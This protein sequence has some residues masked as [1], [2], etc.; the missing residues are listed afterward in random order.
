MSHLLLSYHAL[1]CTYSIPLAKKLRDCGVFGVS[2]DEYLGYAERNREEW[3]MRGQAVVA[4]MVERVQAKYGADRGGTTAINE[5][6][7]F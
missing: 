5:S 3:E 2:S 7:S 1:C 6:S 4:S